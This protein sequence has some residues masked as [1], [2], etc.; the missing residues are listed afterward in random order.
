MANPYAIPYA[1][2]SAVKTAERN[3]GHHPV[4]WR[5]HVG[6][7]MAAIFDADGNHVATVKKDIAGRIVADVNMAECAWGKVE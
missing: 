1:K 4:P 5:V 7:D 6:Y 2:F 3:S